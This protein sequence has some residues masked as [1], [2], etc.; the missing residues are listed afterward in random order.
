MINERESVCS[1][2]DGDNIDTKYLYRICRLLSK[3]FYEKYGDNRKEIRNKIF[4]W[5]NRN[6]IFIDFDLN[7]CIDS[8]LDY[9]YVP[10]K[11]EKNPIYVSEYDVS[12]IIDRFDNK[13]IRLV[14][15]G[16]LLYAK[17][18]GT[19]GEF[20]LPITAF[21][22]WVGISGSN[23]ISRYLKPLIDYGYIERTENKVFKW[24]T[25]SKEKV[26]H[27]SSKF[28][29]LVDVENTGF[30]KIT[31]NN[32]N[33]AFNELFK[34][35]DGESRRKIKK[36]SDR[37]SE[38]TIYE[39]FEKNYKSIFGD[40]CCLFNVSPKTSVVPDCMIVKNGVI[41]PVRCKVG[42]FNYRA[43]NQ[44]EEYMSFY[45]CSDG[46]AIGNKL[47][48]KIDKNIRFIQHPY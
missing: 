39:W 45:K 5:A 29:I 36:E 7:D 9:N 44:L 1:W 33:K 22:N 2:L 32:I 27:H 4:D 20:I 48:V 31:N 34:Y 18:F 6:K 8:T 23:I 30:Y 41:Y 46:I 15:F 26:R 47:N 13:N 43:L 16:M 17:Q 3:F 35:S 21:G 10:L 11:D 25:L 38:K 42:S 14:A 37:I 24:N 28:K 19:N 12:S 40:N